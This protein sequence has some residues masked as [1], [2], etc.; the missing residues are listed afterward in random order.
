M[1][2][3]WPHTIPTEV[4]SNPLAQLNELTVAQRR[5]S[6][7]VVDEKFQLATIEDRLLESRHMNPEQRFKALA[8]WVLPNDD[9][10]QFRLYGTFTSPNDIPGSDY[11]ATA[12]P[13]AKQNKVNRRQYSGPDL[14]SPALDL[15]AV[16]REL[17]H[18]DDLRQYT[19]P[20]ADD[21]AST[22]RSKLALRTIIQV[23]SGQF[24][25][26]TAGLKQLC[27]LSEALA[28][29]TRTFDRWSELLAAHAAVQHAETR[30]AALPLLTLLTDQSRRHQVDVSWGNQVVALR[31]RC[32]ALIDTNQY[33]PIGGS[34]PKQQWIGSRVESAQNQRWSPASRWQFRDK[35]V[36]HLAG[37]GQSYLYFQSPLKGTFTVEAEVTTSR[38]NEPR[39]MY[40]AH[41]VGPDHSKKKI[42]LGVLENQSFGPRLDPK[43]EFDDWCQ[44]KLD[45]TPNK[46]TYSIN[47]RQVHE[48]LLSE[49]LDPWLALLAN[50]QSNAKA[51]NIRITGAPEIP[52]ELNLTNGDDLIGWTCALYG[53]PMIANGN[54]DKSNDAWRKSANEIVGTKFDGMKNQKRQSLL[55]YHRPLAEDTDLTYEFYYSKDETQHVH[56]A[57]GRLAMLIHGEGVKLHWLTDPDSD[58]YGLKPDNEASAVSVGDQTQTRP[59]SKPELKDK[60]WNQ[61][62]IKIEGDNLQLILNGQSILETVL[63]A[64]NQR[65]F[66]FFHYANETEVKVRNVLY[67]GNWPKT[68]PGIDQQELSGA[69]P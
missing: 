13:V 4:A 47:G 45:V 51:R 60:T 37:E 65:Q 63:D 16:A 21:V 38:W 7:M 69:I 33:P 50:G 31:D 35:T 34:S 39:L 23:E 44:L 9:H 20:Q 6:A 28:D 58:R 41:S 1:Q 14:A 29:N 19:E 10:G 32:Q 15:V 18:L 42:A 55:R 5:G 22:K 53:D 64:S 36:S 3:N 24:A 49:K 48:Q 43:L 12:P 68:L 46:A 57:I 40:H 66:G 27:V 59:L 61:V 30:V 54:G 17:N 26:A 56:P 25:E 2:G 67:K 11:L 62:Q 52:A 8:A